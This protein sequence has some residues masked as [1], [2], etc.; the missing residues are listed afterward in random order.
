MAQKGLNQPRYPALKG[1][2]DAKRKQIEERTISP[3]ESKVEVPCVEETGCKSS[4]QDRGNR[5]FCGS[6]TSAIAA[7]RGKS[8]LIILRIKKL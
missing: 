7:R 3:V 1:I 4:R 2:M 8:Y 5:C 6:R